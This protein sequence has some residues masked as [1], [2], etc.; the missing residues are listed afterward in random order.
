MRDKLVLKDEV[1]ERLKN[2]ASISEPL[3]AAALK[4]AERFEDDPLELD[5]ASRLTVLEPNRDAQDYRLAVRQAEAACHVEKS[6]WTYL[7]TLATAQHRVGHHADALATLERAVEL[8]RIETGSA[9]PR[10]LAVAAMA[11]HQ[12][13][14]AEESREYFT[15]LC[16][17]MR[18]E[19]WAR[20]EECPILPARSQ[21][22]IQRMHAPKTST[23]R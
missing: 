1:L 13:G 6:S 9:A 23:K 18:G 22:G 5:G 21:I 8:S 17:L 11:H 4:I 15:R 16:D 12:L 19:G 7:T 10:Q 3:R 14:H 2:D 20:D